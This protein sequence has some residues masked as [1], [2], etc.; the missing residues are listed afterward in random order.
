MSYFLK[1]TVFPNSKTKVWLQK[2]Y[3]WNLIVVFGNEDHLKDCHDIYK[4][5][6]HI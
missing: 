5:I 6:Y 4:F 1:Y 3:N 2:Y